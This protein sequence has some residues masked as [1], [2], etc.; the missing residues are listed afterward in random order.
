MKK[1]LIVLSVFCLTLF[2]E[3]KVISAST[4]E[5]GKILKVSRDKV[6]INWGTEDGIVVGLKMNVYRK[7][8]IIHPVTKERYG[9]GKEVIGQIEIV[10]ASTSF[11]VGKIV[12]SV[13]FFQ[14]GDFVEI[15]FVK[16]DIEERGV[17]Q[18]KGIITDI[19]GD[20]VQ[21]DL[22]KADGVEKGLI[23][24]V[25]R[26]A[27][28]QIHQ[29]TGELI[30]GEKSLVGK[31]TVVSAEKNRSVGEVISSSG[32]I[33]AG[34]LLEL[35][36]YQKGDLEVES[37]MREQ[38]RASQIPDQRAEVTLSDIDV[39]TEQVVKGVVT[40]VE[41]DDVYFLWDNGFSFKPGDKLGIYRQE[42]ITHP[43]TGKEI[44]NKLILIARVELLQST[45]HGGMGK[46]ISKDAAVKWKDLVGILT[47]E[48]PVQQVSS[49]I[50]PPQ[51]KKQTGKPSPQVQ[52]AR[53]LVNEINQ[54]QKEI[55]Y[56]RGLQN[57]INNI[58]K[59]VAEQK[60][61]TE[62]LEKT[63]NQILEAVAPELKEGQQISLVP[64]K[65]SM[66]VFDRPGT[67]EHTMRIKYTDD[68]DVKFQVANK[69]LYVTMD[70]DT[71]R[72][73]EASQLESQPSGEVVSEP[74]IQP[75]Q[76]RQ[77]VVEQ[78]TGGQ[79]TPFYKNPIILIGVAVGLLII[80]GALFF[81][82]KMKK[83]KAPKVPVE[84][85]EE[86]TAE[87]EEISAEDE[88]MAEDEEEVFDEEL[89]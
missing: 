60:R 77:A 48:K 19:Q 17:R 31:I 22:G 21:F 55:R 42:K 26:Q 24:D 32:E 6:E 71:P 57:K 43:I 47:D 13:K 29:T 20:R 64:S 8:D 44:G 34:D 38:Q 79:T 84:E 45:E 36:D 69:T 73:R 9:Q 66:E 5:E 62:N 75:S 63:V 61:V 33:Q 7:V 68:I 56:L 80:A 50:P 3:D 81:L 46:I 18:Q 52:E 23:F 30:E 4:F 83:G 28:S 25:Y 35:S 76:T 85:D 1:Y 16:S 49:V 54:I 89:E 58:E 41:N 86:E 40:K 12:S 37:R 65:A 10:N 78:E 39:F 74:E 53:N 15:A 70:A 2:M 87:E 11:S 72:I 88:E 82:M 27:E 14:P 51:G 59:S 67:S